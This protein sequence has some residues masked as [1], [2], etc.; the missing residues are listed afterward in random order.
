M[1]FNTCAMMI[2]LSQF[3]SSPKGFEAFCKSNIALL[4]SIRKL[5][6]LIKATTTEE[7]DFPQTHSWFYDAFKLSYGKELNSLIGH[8]L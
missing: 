1:L 3:T 4:P 5:K 8:I 2:A 6:R 7:G